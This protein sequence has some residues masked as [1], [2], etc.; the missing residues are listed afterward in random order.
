M[1]LSVPLTGI[2]LFIISLLIHVLVWRREPPKNYMGA[3]VVIFI[4]IPTVLLSAATFAINRTGPIFNGPPLN[5]LVDF[6][7]ILLF[8]Y[9]LA[10]GYILSY[11]ALQANCP[12]LTMLLIVARATP[13]GVEREKLQANFNTSKMLEPRL[14]DLIDTDFVTITDGRYKLTKKGG[15]LLG[16]FGFFRKLL[17]LTAGIG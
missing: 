17:G 5:V 13:K 6:L 11:P 16:I 9:S 10:G 3:L 15:L 8:H 1:S 7:A 14:K 2:I 12:T 4:I